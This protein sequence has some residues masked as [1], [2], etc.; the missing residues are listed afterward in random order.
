MK[1]SAYSLIVLS[2]L[3]LVSAIASAQMKPTARGLVGQPGAEAPTA[4]STCSP[5]LWYS[6]DD[7]TANPNWDGL[8]NGNST[9]LG[10]TGQQ[11]VPFVPAP[12]GNPLHLHVLISSVTFN[13]IVRTPDTNPP[14]D[15]AGMTYEFRSK[16]V[17][18]GNGGT[19]GK[20]G[21]CYTTAVL[22][23]GRSPNG[24]NEYAFTCYFK[25]PVKV[26]V[27]TIQWFSLLPTFTTSNF[28]YLVG[29]TDVPA[30]NQFGWSNDMYNSFANSSYWGWSFAPSTS[31][32][33][34]FEQFSV[35]IAGTYTL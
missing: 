29:T 16:E 18:S 20:H 3:V 32:A 27:G 34:G 5:C 7:D 9:W 26:A 22:Y 2:T 21:G 19:L 8:W 31:V 35:A 23:T 15:F 13:L 28:A 10:I 25:A 12:D 11:Y 33:S 24:Y 17:F 6:G 4:P 30:P 14:A 1:F